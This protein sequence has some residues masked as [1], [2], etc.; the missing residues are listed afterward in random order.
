MAVKAFV[1]REPRFYFGMLM[2]GVVVAD[3]MNLFSLGNASFDEI[4]KLDPY[5]MPV[6][7]LAGS[8]E[9]AAQDV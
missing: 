2:R 3:Q 8:D 6:F 9:G 5:L 1:A 4:E 7:L